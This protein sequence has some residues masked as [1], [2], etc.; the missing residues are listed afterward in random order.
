[1]GQI[2]YKE[3]CINQDEI[4]WVEIDWMPAE[5]TMTLHYP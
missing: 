4:I 2:F 3:H 1:L 5:K